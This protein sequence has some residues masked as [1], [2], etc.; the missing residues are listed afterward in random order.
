M[1]ILVAVS[2]I[3]SFHI[4]ERI[5]MGEGFAYESKNV[6]FGDNASNEKLSKLRTVLNKIQNDYYKDYSMDD[7]I[8][9]AIKG[10]VNALGDPYTRYYTREEME[11]RRNQLS[12]YY[13]GIGVTISEQTPDYLVIGEVK[14]NSPAAEAELQEGDRIVAIDGKLIREWS[15]DSIINLLRTEGQEIELEINRDGESFSVTLTVRAI[16]IVSVTAREINAE[17]GYIHISQF[18]TKAANLFENELKI[19]VGKG[20]KG[21]V[22]DLRNNG[23]GLATEMTRIADT[24]LPGGMQIYYVVDKTGKTLETQYATADGINI[25]IVILI[26][27]K[28]ASAAEILASTLRDNLGS[29]M[30]GKNSFG[31][32]V[33]QETVSFYSDGSGL[34]I[35]VSQ[36]FT[37]SKVN[38]QDKGLKPDIEVDLPEHLQSVDIEKIPPEEDTQLEQA[39][40]ELKKIIASGAGEE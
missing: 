15:I 2:S 33:A 37:P 19:L 38:I 34:V 21:L 17:I 1:V 9:G 13:Y 11:Q 31:K 10:I 22:L 7:L 12:G 32:A 20:I 39:V 28:T 26:N 25:P 40:S 16:D 5:F 27:E 36:Y 8:E 24:I 18:D 35:T 23:G 4:A 30:V 6:S 14:E 29:K 3:V